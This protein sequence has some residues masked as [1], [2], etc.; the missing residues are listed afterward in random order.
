MVVFSFVLVIIVWL[1]PG[2]YL[3]KRNKINITHPF[4]FFPLFVVYTAL[5]P[6]SEYV[7]GWSAKFAAIGL[8]AVSS[9]I[10][11]SGGYAYIITNIYLIIS[12]IFYFVGVY[13]FTKGIPKKA[14]FI[15]IQPI[16]FKK[17]KLKVLLYILLLPVIVG[18]ILFVNISESGNYFVTQIFGL[19][20]YIPGLLVL[21]NFYAFMLA[22]I[23]AIP[24]VTVILSKANIFYLFLWSFI[25]FDFIKYK[26]KFKKTFYILSICFGL[27]LASWMVD[28]RDE[29]TGPADTN[30]IVG[31]FY[32]FFFREYGYDVFASDVYHAYNNDKI[33]TKSYLFGEF[34]EII[35]SSVYE[36]L[37]GEKKV[38]MGNL[39]GY[40][41]L[42]EYKAARLGVGYNRYFLT[43]FYHDLGVIGVIIGSFIIGLMNGYWFKKNIKLFLKTNNRIH[44]ARYLTIPL[45][46][47]YLINGLIFYFLANFIFMNILISIFKLTYK[48]TIINENSI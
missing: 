10:I 21:F 11:L 6:F 27:F 28:K 35:P 45:N 16:K 48:K 12:A 38:R 23:I 3:I 7:F 13:I 18:P 32:T 39:V 24:T 43:S 42:R 5:V 15:R 26:I 9:E 17:I 44:I 47:H 2:I 19:T 46:F 8:R 33:N 36:N 34:A 4:V 40:E 20:F 41:I 30:Q 14:N 29:F 1:T 31:L 25:P 37:F 22:F